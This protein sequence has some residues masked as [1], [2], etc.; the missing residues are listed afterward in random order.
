MK[1]L[2]CL[3]TLLPLATPVSA[4]P[5]T[6][7]QPQ[8]GERG[9]QMEV[10]ESR[11]WLLRTNGQRLRLPLRR[12]E[13]IEE[14]VEFEN[15]WAAAGGRMIGARRELAVVIDDVAGVE[16]LRPVPEQIGDLRVRPVPLASANGLEG[17][18]WLEGDSPTSYEVRVA[19]W[20]G[21]VWAPPRIVSAAQSGG[22]AGL[23]GTVLDDGRWLLVWSASDGSTSD[24][25][26]SVRED[27]R[28]TTPHKLAAANQSPDVAPSLIRVS[29][30][31]LLVWARQQSPGYGL[32]T[33]RFGRS[34]SAPRR[35][36]ADVAW[37]P[38]FAEL[39]GSGRFLVHRSPGGWTTVEL[40]ANGRELRRAETV[41]RKRER[42][43]LMPVASGIALRWEPKE[44]SLQLRW[45]RSR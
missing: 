16:R 45:E 42:P 8:S 25:V 23:V 33:A 32:H 7:L 17:L 14:V 31:A 1:R 19:E 28:W 40:D 6:L 38:R 12:G 43:V 37:S 20:T 35:L 3:L 29:D 27:G 13:R 9:L 21:A 4:A 11:A 10:T 30:G 26:W 18:A 15:G 5:A 36:G 39:A 24:L 34:W 44:R 41:S 22:Q 2:V